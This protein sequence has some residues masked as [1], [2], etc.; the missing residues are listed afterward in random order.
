MEVEDDCAHGPFVVQA[1]REVDY[2][3]EGDSEALSDA[4]GSGESTLAV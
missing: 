2:V 3:T 4:A 1:L